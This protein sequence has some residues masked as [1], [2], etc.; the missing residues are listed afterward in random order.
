MTLLAAPPKP[1][2]P[3]NPSRPWPIP[4]VPSWAM[5][6]PDDMP[7]PTTPA[8]PPPPRPTP[9]VSLRIG[10]PPRL[11]RRERYVRVLNQSGRYLLAYGLVGWACM[12]LVDV[13]LFVP[14]LVFAAMVANPWRPKSAVRPGEVRLRAAVHLLLLRGRAAARRGPL[15]GQFPRTT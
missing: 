8:P 2:D 5:A 11:S 4:P 12:W 13:H 1:P 14:G 3:A 10:R 15:S 9:G 6:R 7:V